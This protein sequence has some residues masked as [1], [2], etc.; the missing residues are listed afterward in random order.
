MLVYDQVL[1]VCYVMTALVSFG[2]ARV[3]LWGGIRGILSML[4]GTFV[5]V[6][7]FLATVGQLPPTEVF[8][9]APTWPVAAWC[10]ASGKTST[11]W[12]LAYFK[13]SS[14]GLPN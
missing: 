6:G 11:E 7:I 8:R 3:L 14:Q 13:L 4:F 9:V 1:I 5:G 2:I 12:C 10:S